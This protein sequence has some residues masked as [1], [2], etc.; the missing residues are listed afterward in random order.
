MR[1][2]RVSLRFNRLPDA[3]FLGFAANIIDKMSGN[4]LFPTP[5]VSMAELQSRLDAFNS[6]LVATGQ[7]GTVATAAKNQCR[8]ELLSALRREASYVQGICRHD[9]AGMLSS[10]FQPVKQNNLQSPL[11]RPDILKILNARSEQLVLSVTPVRN[12]RNYQVQ[13]RIGR[14]EWQDGGVF[15][16]ARRLEVGN[17]TPGT[18]YELRVRALGGS[19]GY[20]DWSDPVQRMSL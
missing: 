13:W 6:A 8:A 2:Y 9:E 1:N 18:M 12:A 10:G 17:L 7:G 11:E 19:T 20:S 5:L 3:D 16:K 4:T 14:A 15:S